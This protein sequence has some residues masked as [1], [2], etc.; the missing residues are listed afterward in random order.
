MA[1]VTV[2]GVRVLCG[3]VG[4]RVPQSLVVV[5]GVLSCSR[6]MVRF[7]GYRSLVQG[8]RRSTLMVAFLQRNL[9]QV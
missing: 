4:L 5:L 3:H 8:L 1:A 7:R 6:F 9:H 2:A